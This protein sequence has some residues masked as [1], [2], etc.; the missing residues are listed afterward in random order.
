[1]KKINIFLLIISAFFINAITNF[2]SCVPD[3]TC[4]N[5][6]YSIWSFLAYLAGILGTSIISLGLSVIIS[7]I[8]ILI[9]KRKYDFLYYFSISFIILS[10]IFLFIIYTNYTYNIA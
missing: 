9:N 3:S 4:I 8:I 5:P 7:F 1:M 2:F 6:F 10:L